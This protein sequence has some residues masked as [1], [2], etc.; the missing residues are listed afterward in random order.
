MI[1]YNRIEVER[2]KDKSSPS[3]ISIMDRTR[4]W[5]IR[6]KNPRMTAGASVVF[7]E[8]AKVAICETGELV[9]GENSF[10]HAGCW[11]LLTMP[12]P[13]VNIGR[14]VFVG[15]N[16][17]IAA[18]NKII[19]GDYTVIAPNC[20]VIDHEHGFSSENIILNQSSVLKSVVI[21][22][23]CYLGTGA[24]VLGGVTIGDGA[25]IGAGS[26]VINDIPEE[27]VWAGNPAKFIKK[28]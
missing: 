7:K 28:R 14:W 3:Q 19:I 27:E 25:I 11:L 24:V 23:D 18:K 15:R 21:G 17:I 8:N 16:S 6:R 22:R 26:I 20:Y 13:K 5:W 2:L 12:K 1:D 4:G 10:F 9:I